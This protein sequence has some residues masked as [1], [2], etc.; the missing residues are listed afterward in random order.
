VGLQSRTPIKGVISGVALE[1]IADDITEEL[2][3]VFEAY[4]C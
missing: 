3:G 1:L 2:D 4:Y